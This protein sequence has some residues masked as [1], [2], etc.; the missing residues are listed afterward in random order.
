MSAK[1]LVY[2]A[3]PVAS[4]F[5][6]S[7]AFVRGIRG[8]VGS[9]KS[10]ACCIEMFKKSQEQA[11]GPDGKRKTRWLVVRNTLPQL[12]TTTIKTWLDWFP[13]KDFGRMTGKP[14][15]THYVRFG[16]V[17]MEVIFIALDKP[18]DVKKLLSFECT[19]IWF[20]EARE[21]NKEIVDAATGRVGRYPSAKDGGCS[22]SGIIM[23]TNPP[24]DS[25]WW[26][27]LS[28]EQTPV[29]WQFFTQPSGLS[30]M[31]ENLENLNQPSD[32]HLLPLATRRELGRK[33]YQRMLGG[34]TQEW[35]NVYVHG[36]YGFIKDGKPVYEASWNDTLH[37]AQADIEINPASPL[38]CGIDCSGR[39][40]SAVW[41]QRTPLG[42]IQIVHEL[43]CEG[44][45][46]VAFAGLLKSEIAR[47]FP[48]RDIEYWGDPAGGYGSQN[49]DRTYFDIIRE[50][51]GVQI[52]P[53]P[54]TNLIGERIQT[55]ESVLLR[56]VTGGVPALWVSRACKILR[57]GF[58]GG[59][60]YKRLSVSGG[61]RYEDKPDKRTRFADVHDALQ[62]LLIG[63]GEGRRMKGQSKNSSK[64][65]A[66][67]VG[68]NV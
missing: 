57:R 3:A 40:P 67:K 20:N 58:N 7:A 21:I 44:I 1:T 53:A 6:Q 17:D 12:E 68:V 13:T 36:K 62:Y 37:G 50:T 8:P 48:G 61:A 66:A 47:V 32:A 64:P 15:Y 18:E 41:G 54:T 46:A 42:Q 60:K 45:G 65:S 2:N 35:I 55:V 22:W 63:M 29:D 5:H 16:D 33:Y 34:K 31:A 24:D 49:D 23:D 59:Y 39:N 27:N 56:L 25:H 26:Y 30:P 14:P 52:R 38:S 10:V 4:L 51:A 43:V 9:G 11:L 28:E 19:G